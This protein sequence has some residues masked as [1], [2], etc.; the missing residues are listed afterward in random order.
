MSMSIRFANKVGLCLLLVVAVELSG[1]DGAQPV[2]RQAVRA[3]RV[4]SMHAP[5][6]A[7]L[8]VRAV[9]DHYEIEVTSPA[10]FPPSGLDPVLHVGAATFVR[11]AYSA[12]VGLFGIVYAVSAAEFATLE[13]GAQV[14]VDHGRGG[15]REQFGTFSRSAVR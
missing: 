5:T 11:Y 1:C 6:D 10:G 4:K 13:D 3:A 15:G 12:T 9:G 8:V 7:G 14:Y 2:Q